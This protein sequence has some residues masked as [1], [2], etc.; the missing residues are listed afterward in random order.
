MV[1][2]VAPLD[3]RL[4]KWVDLR[5]GREGP[6]AVPLPARRAAHT[7]RHRHRGAAGR[8]HA[9]PSLSTQ[10]VAPRTETEKAI[11]G[12]WEH[13]LGI[14]P[15]GV[16]DKF[17]ELGGHSL[18]AVQLLAR[19]AG[20]VRPRPAGPAD[21]RGADRRPAGRRH[22]PAAKTATDGSTADDPGLDE[23]L[24]LVEGLSEDELEALLAE[25]GAP[26]EEDHR[27]WMTWPSSSRISRRSG[28]PGWSSC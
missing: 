23:M 20:D 19:L 28:G 18:L 27:E 5:T 26:A 22:R 14:A 10:F 4:A 8:T 11:A 9:R 16:H 12:V 3:E 7:G 25:V 15:I 1:V 24:K 6:A 13:L 21:L 2:A 17:F